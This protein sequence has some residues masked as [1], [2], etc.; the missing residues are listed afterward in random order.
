M[1]NRAY[2]AILAI[3]LIALS[4]ALSAVDGQTEDGLH[5]REAE[6]SHRER[7]DPVVYEFE[8]VADATIRHQDPDGSFGTAAHLQVSPEVYTYPQR[9]LGINALLR[10][11]VSDIPGDAVVQSARL[12][13][14]YYRYEYANPAYRA[15]AVWPLLEDWDEETV[16]WS[17]R[18]SHSPQPTSSASMPN[19][20][21]QWLEWQVT[22]D[23]QHHVAHPSDNHGWL[24]GDSGLYHINIYSPV[25]FF[26]SREAQENGPRLVVEVANDPP[27]APTISGPARG[28]AGMPYPYTI[29]ATDPDG[30]RLYYRVQ[31]GGDGDS[32]GWL[33]PYPSGEAITLEHAWDTRGTYTISA[34][35]RDAHGAESDWGTLEVSM[36]LTRCTLLGS[37]LKWLAD[38]LLLFP[39]EAA[40]L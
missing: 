10:F 3:G 26:R 39:G 16:S 14:Y 25:S 1:T 21:Q 23:V 11:D 24:V 33:G 17:T 34:Q 31:W 36:P 12:M 37:I 15:V 13:M 4:G 30:N 6:L 2:A 8:A 7:L 18:P 38:A 9:T 20:T 29:A 28:K 40:G 35:A 32:S 22:A 27:D 5:L 19:T